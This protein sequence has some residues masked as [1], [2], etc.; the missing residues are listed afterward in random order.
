MRGFSVF[1]SATGTPKD[2]E[3]THEKV[4]YGPVSFVPLQSI[5]F[6]RTLKFT[7]QTFHPYG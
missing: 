7:Y 4:K 3:T 2:A 5:V 6:A 1:L